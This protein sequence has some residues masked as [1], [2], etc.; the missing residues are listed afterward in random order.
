MFQIF[1]K[2]KL[3]SPVSGKSV[4]LTNVKDE[5]FSSLMMGDGIAIDPTDKVIVAPCDC[6]VKLIMKGSKHALGLLMNNGVEV[7]IHVGIDT[8]SLE[9]KGFKV[10]V[11][12]GQK[13]KLGTPLLNFDK[14]YIISKGYSTM[15][16]MIITEANGSNINKKYE[17]IRVQG[18]ETPV[19]EFS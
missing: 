18:G 7:L 19:I 8:V 10:L 15:T 3:Y 13:V 4:A 12:E 5:V 9:G 11:E 16:M 17:D 1:K 6:T 2:K 14:D